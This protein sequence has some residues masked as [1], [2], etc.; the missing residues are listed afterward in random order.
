MTFPLT[1][2]ADSLQPT[3]AGEHHRDLRL[4]STVEDPLIYIGPELF[5]TEGRVIQDNICQPALAGLRPG[6]VFSRVVRRRYA[7]SNT[8]SRDLARVDSH[9]SPVVSGDKCSTE[10]IPRTFEYPTVTKGVITIILVEN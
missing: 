8:G 7:G 6:T 3:P 9:I 10:R 1:G 5:Q 4:M 2:S